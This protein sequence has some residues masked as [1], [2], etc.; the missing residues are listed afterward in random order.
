MSGENEEK[1][2]PDVLAS[3]QMTVIG[4]PYTPPGEARRSY[5]GWGLWA[6]TKTQFIISSVYDTIDANNLIK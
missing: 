5:M 4:C 2:N 6:L 3:R 1:Y